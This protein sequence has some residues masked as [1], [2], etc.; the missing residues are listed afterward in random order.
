YERM[1][2]PGDAPFGPGRQVP[3]RL[4]LTRLVPEGDAVEEVGPLDIPGV[5]GFRTIALVL[6][7][8]L[9][10]LRKA[11]R[12]EDV[13]AVADTAV[14]GGVSLPARLSE[15][16]TGAGP[17]APGVVEVVLAAG[18]LQARDLFAIDVEEVI[19]LAEPTVL[20][21]RDRHH[22]AGILSASFDV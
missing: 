10:R 15:P 6:H 11:D 13:P 5:F 7:R 2:Q 16:V 20:R 18:P 19:S 14:S 4:R 8:H 17:K 21:H 1:A 9:Q 22:R 3:K 12:I